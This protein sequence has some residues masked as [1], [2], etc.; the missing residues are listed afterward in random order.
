MRAQY[1]LGVCIY[2]SYYY[3]TKFTVLI[4]SILLIFQLPYINKTKILFTIEFI[5]TLI[6]IQHG[7]SPTKG[8]HRLL[9]KFGFVPKYPVPFGNKSLYEKPEK[10]YKAE[11]FKFKA[12]K[13]GLS[14]V[15]IKGL[16]QG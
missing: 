12:D 9:E 5:L 13:K 7:A 15:S 8:T 4:I 10:E 3:H 2:I 1:W 6:L 16:L 11:H 14:E